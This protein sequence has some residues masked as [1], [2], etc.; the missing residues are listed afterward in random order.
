[1]PTSKGS[2]PVLYTPWNIANCIFGYLDVRLH[3]SIS[4]RFEESTQEAFHATHPIV[5]Q[6]F[7]LIQA[8]QL[9]VSLT[10]MKYWFTI[11]TLAEAIKESNPFL[12]AEQLSWKVSDAEALMKKFASTRGGTIPF[13]PDSLLDRRCISYATHEHLVRCDRR[14][15][16]HYSRCYRHIPLNRCRG[17]KRG[18]QRCSRLLRNKEMC[19]AHAKGCSFILPPIFDIK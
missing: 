14:C 7:A 13:M 6:R 12:N 11:P 16:K 5:R 3:R 19:A 17:R 1:M 2:F 9:K 8:G 18:G 15:H 10:T 4:K